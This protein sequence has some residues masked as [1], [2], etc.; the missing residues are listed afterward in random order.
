MLDIVVVMNEG[1]SFRAGDKDVSFHGLGPQNKGTQPIVM[2]NQSLGLIDKTSGKPLNK[3]N[4]DVV[5]DKD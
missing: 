5:I 2:E 1:T 3:F 4:I